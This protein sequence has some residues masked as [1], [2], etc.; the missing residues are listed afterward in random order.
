MD[1][2]KHT[3]FYLDQLK[4]LVGGAIEGTVRTD[5][6]E[7]GDEFFGLAIRCKDGAVRRF[8]I[9]SD[10]EGIGPGSFE[11]VEGESHG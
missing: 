10:D 11:I 8:I 9:L 4:P 6:D 3:Q 5:G 2:N 1:A 7:F